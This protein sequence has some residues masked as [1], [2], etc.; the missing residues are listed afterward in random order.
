MTAA[1]LAPLLEVQDLDIAARAAQKRSVE[2]SER[3]LIPK[4]NAKIARAEAELAAARQ[5]RAG[6]ETTEE[7]LGVSV[8]QIAKDLENAEV[9]RY[10]G[11]QKSRDDAKAHDASQAA[12][13]DKK[14]AIEEQEMELLEAIEGV[15]GRIALLE[16]EIAKARAEGAK[17]VDVIGQVE[18]EVA[19]ELERLAAERAQRTGGIPAPVLSAYERVRD[20]KGKAG[21]GAAVLEKGDCQGC[22]IKL[23]SLEKKRLLAEPEDALIQCPQCR[24]VLVR[25]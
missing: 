10:S 8:E 14:S 18:R 25:I 5:E 9:E 12:L 11:K 16:G 24:L 6:F 7:Q 15:E 17:A 22:R 19:G 2:L 4:I 3:A 1:R 21:R 13:R 20:Q 23:P